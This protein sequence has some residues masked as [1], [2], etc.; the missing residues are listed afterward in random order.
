[1]SAPRLE[2]HGGKI[3]ANAQCLVERLGKRG[4]A[5]TGVTKAALGCPVIALALLDAGV[6]GLG[7]SRIENI[8][9]MRAALGDGPHITLIRSPMLSQ[10]A[11]VV[12]SAN[13]SF[14]TEL[15]VIQALSDAA[16]RT[17]NIHGVVLMVELGDLREGIMADALLA[18]VAAV[19]PMPNIALKGIGTNL[20]CL[21]GTTPDAGNMAA[22]SAHAAMIEQAFGITLDIISGGNS[23]NLDWALAAHDPGRINDL[24]LG[25]A[26]LFG[27]E[28]LG[29]NPIQGLHLDAFRLVAEVIEAKVKPSQPWGVIAQ[30]AFGEIVPT[31][32]RGDIFQA[33]LAMGRQDSDPTGLEPP[34]GMT[35]LGASSDH[36]VI[37]TGDQLAA[38]GTEM[39]FGI[40]YATLLRAMASPFVE[41]I[42]QVGTKC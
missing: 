34:A 35:I 15:V 27:R 40:N 9:R 28:T 18:T 19:L 33:I 17:N 13:I 14:N 11:R 8:E 23:A 16:K 4:I 26:I 42:M 21:S 36:L 24:R 31:T 20:A 39:A 1:M 2:I 38:V 30:N 41:K 6:S 22:L 5:V 12:R 32:D 25:E 10:A 29:R 7:D 3:A 37:D